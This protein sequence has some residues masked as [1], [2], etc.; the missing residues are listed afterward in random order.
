MTRIILCGFY[1]KY[2][3]LHKT[4]KTDNHIQRP[5]VTCEVNISILLFFPIPFI[6]LFTYLSPT[7]WKI[8]G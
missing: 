5:V 6:Y 4:G 2:I 8:F 1:F 3:K 7:I